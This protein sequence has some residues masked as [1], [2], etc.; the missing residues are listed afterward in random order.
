MR[1]E[2]FIKAYNERRIAAAGATGLAVRNIRDDF[3]NEYQ[4]RGISCANDLARMQQPGMPAAFA[5]QGIGR[6]DFWAYA[7]PGGR[8]AVVPSFREYTQELHAQG[9][10]SDAFDS[11]FRGTSSHNITVLRPAIFQGLT[12]VEQKGQ[13]QLS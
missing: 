8:Y 2:A 13:L 10:G 4:L 5:E 3:I 1:Y 7:L 6:A 11:N 9:G 12:T